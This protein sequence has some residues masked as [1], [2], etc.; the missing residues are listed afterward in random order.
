MYLNGFNDTFKAGF[1]VKLQ[2]RGGNSSG[3]TFELKSIFE[4]MAKKRPY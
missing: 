2:D 4:E 1:T 3:I